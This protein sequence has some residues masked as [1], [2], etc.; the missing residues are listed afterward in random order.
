M[1]LSTPVL[2]K[3]AQHRLQIRVVALG[4]RILPGPPSLAIRCSAAALQV[5]SPAAMCGTPSCR[6]QLLL[7]GLI[8]GTV[9]ALLHTRINVAAGEESL[10]RAQALVRAELRD[11][12]ERGD[13]A[14]CPAG[15]DIEVRLGAGRHSSSSPTGLELSAADSKWATFFFQTPLNLPLEVIGR[16][17]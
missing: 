6:L 10:D 14:R 17:T 11:R 9:D 1:L 15:G 2:S 5:S 4:K 16:E 12:S 13:G 7:L 8:V 3:Q